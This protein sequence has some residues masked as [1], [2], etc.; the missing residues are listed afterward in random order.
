[1][2]NGLRSVVILFVLVGLLAAACTEESRDKIRESLPSGVSG[3]PSALPSRGPTGPTGGT[4]GEP[5][6]PTG[7]TGPVDTPTEEPTEPPTESPANRPKARPADRA[8]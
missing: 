4:P 5:T 8:G 3:L 1:L 6:A 7:P 2:S